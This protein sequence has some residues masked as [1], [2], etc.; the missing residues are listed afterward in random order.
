MARA[1]ARRTSRRWKGAASAC[2]ARPSWSPSGRR[3]A[4]AG[5]DRVDSAV[6]LGP[7]LC[8]PAERRRRRPVRPGLAGGDPGHSIVVCDVQNDGVRVPVRSRGRG[9]RL[10]VRVA[11]EPHLTP[12]RDVRDPVRASGRERDFRGFGRRVGGHGV[13]VRERQPVEDLIVRPPEADV[14]VPAASSASTSEIVPSTCEP[15]DSR[16]SDRSIPRLIPRAAA[17]ARW[18]SGCPCGS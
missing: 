7:Q 11:L 4:A 14:T 6:Q 1:T 12:W 17:A 13:R 15:S 8:P 9:P 5:H 10:E 2:S 18:R 16:A 3:C